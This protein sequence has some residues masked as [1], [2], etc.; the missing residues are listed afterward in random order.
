MNPL[1]IIPLVVGFIITLFSIPIWIKRS[2]NAGLIGKDMHSLEKKG[3]SSTGGVP[4]LIGFVIGVL[5]YI[6]I[7]TFYFQTTENLISTLS[8]LTSIFII[9]FVGLI[10]DILGWKIGLTKKIRIFLL[11]FAAIPLMVINAGD[12]QMMGIEF[13]ILYPLILIPLGI[14]GASSAYN[15]LAG[16]NGLESSQG[17]LILSGLAFVAWKT[18]NGGI[19]VIALTMVACL[20]SFYIFN[21]HPAKVFPGNILT[22]SI[23]ALIAGVAILGNI[24]KIAVFFFIPYI[25]E[26]ILKLRGGLKKESF[27]KVNGDGS[28]EM[29]YDKIYGLEHLAIYILKRVKKSGKAY[30]KEVVYL[31]NLFQILIMSIGYLL[32]L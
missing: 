19:G 5:S 20:I 29:P 8:L 23:G 13:G 25:I 31:I 2:K 26:T 15:I 7:K 1:V 10:D 14:V 18:G 3:V 4:V 12:H 16:Y 27:A 6:A 28:L 17:I 9:S 30:E 24:E 11:I 22:Y 32:L 21:K